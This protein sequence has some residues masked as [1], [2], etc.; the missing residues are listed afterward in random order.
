MGWKNIPAEQRVVLLERR[1]AGEDVLDLAKEVGMRPGTLARRRRELAAGMSG[2]RLRRPKSPRVRYDAPEVLEGDAVVTG[3]FQLPY[4][5][6]E[7]AEYMLEIARGS[8]L[9][10]PRLV[11]CG[12]F[13]N[14]DA[15][16]PF[17]PV[18]TYRATFKHEVECAL[19]FLVDALVVFD[20]IDVFVGNHERRIYYR[21]LGQLNAES[22][23]NL[24]GVKKVRFHDYSH[25]ILSTRTG[26]WRLTHQRNFSRN[27]L[28]VGVKLA[29]KFRQH[30]VTHHQHRVGIGFDDSGQNVVV[31]NGCMADPA[32][33][34]YAQVDD[35]T[36]PAM[37]QG[38]C[39]IK[40]GVVQ[41]YANHPA[42]MSV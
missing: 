6:Y 22:L 18:N 2:A 21:T 24:V 26:E 5:D 36:T 27:A 20:S 25:C 34:D 30:I 11:I 3:D 7:F 8:E 12:D 16:S 15:F 40:D 32:M 42:L 31:D 1:N 39:V 14:M 38:F 37:N 17:P 35:S 23:R 33:L 9:S 28:S 10:P 41:L 13:F 29:H 4:L 19:S